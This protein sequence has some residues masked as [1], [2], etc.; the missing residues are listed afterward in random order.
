MELAALVV[1]ETLTQMKDDLVN[2]KL[3]ELCA[4][5]QEAK[6]LYRNALLERG[7]LEA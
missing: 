6:E 3:I 1:A 5:D 7:I 2:I 4:F